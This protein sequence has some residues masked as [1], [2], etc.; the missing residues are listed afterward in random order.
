MQE[1][2]LPSASHW[3]W[4]YRNL[5]W[6]LAIVGIAIRVQQYLHNRSLWLDEALIALNLLHRSFHQ[7]TEQLDFH[8]VAPPAWLFIEKASSVMFGKSE[9]ALRLPVLLSGVLAML[10]L[11]FLGKR[12]LS[13]RALCI[14]VGL[15]AFS[16]PLIYYSSELKPYG[17]DVA[18][19]VATWLLGFWTLQRPSLARIA[20][21]AL[22]GGIATWLSHPALFVVAGLGFTLICSLAISRDWCSLASFVPVFLVWMA[23]FAANFWLFL[24]PG[25]HDPVLLNNYPALRLSLWHVEDIERPFETIFALQQNPITIFL[26]VLVFVFCVGCLH[27]WRANRVAFSFLFSPL[28][29]ALAASSLHRYP[30]VGRFYLFYTPVLVILAA[31]G[32]EQVLVASATSRLHVGAVLLALLF[33]QPMLSMREIVAHPIEATELRPVLQ[34]VQQHQ[35]PGDVWYVYCF[36]RFAF[37]YYAEVYGLTSP[38]VV[39]GRCPSRAQRQVFQQDASMLCGKQVWTIIADPWAIGGAN[40]LDLVLQAFSAAGT[41]RQSYSRVGAVAYLYEMSPPPGQPD[42]PAATQ[43]H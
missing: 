6:L 39:V 11:P 13:D 1:E 21:L 24:R 26:G 25:T 8:N 14:A 38:N 29:F 28:L 41:Q 2:G 7:L 17:S 34:F 10:L 19:A 32:A 5:T 27:Y 12:L 4:S 36:T 15:F 35:H 31:A 3:T 23:S 42:R 16:R 43:L 20:V 9:L 22:W 30:M 33:V 37:Q 40:D 18:V